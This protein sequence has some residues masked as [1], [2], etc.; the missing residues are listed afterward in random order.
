VGKLGKQVFKHYAETECPRQLFLDLAN[1]DP[2]WIAPFR[3]I[4]VD[5]QRP[6]GKSLADLG[7]TYEQTV[8]R[9]MRRNPGTRASEAPDSGDVAATVLDR[10]RWE[11]YADA[12]TT[13]TPTLFL[14]EHQCPTPEEFVRFVFDLPPDA[15][16]PTLEVTGTMR[17]DIL[18]LRHPSRIGTHAQEVM[19]DGA[20]RP[21]SPDE[22]A[23]R[24]AIELVDIK[25]THEQAVG[26]THLIEILYY[27]IALSTLLRTL[28]LEG[29]FFVSAHGHGILPRREPS[30]VSTLRTQEPAA[31]LVPLRWRDTL[32]LFAGARRALIAL[33]RATP[34]PIEAIPAH[35]QSACGRCGY[36][37]DCTKSLS[38]GTDPAAWDVSLLP[39]LKQGTAV[40]LRGLGIATVGD[41][42]HR[43]RA[44][45]QRGGTLPL[46][47]EVP[48]LELQARALLQGT[49]LPA[50]P[51]N[52][53]GEQMLSIALP[54]YADVS[55]L[56]DF[57][58]DPTNDVV[59]ALGL[60]FTVHASPGAGYAAIHDAWWAFWQAA[61]A[62]TAQPDW[63][64]LDALLDPTTR[65]QCAKDAAARHAQF[66]AFWRCL[67]QL[68]DAPRAVLEFSEWPDAPAAPD[69]GRQR[70]SYQYTYVNGGS[71]V[72]DTHLVGEH[73]LV[74]RA[75]TTLHAIF[76][77][78][79]V[80]ETYVAQSVHE[81]NDKGV[82]KVWFKR[83]NFAGFYWSREQLV[84]VQDL[85]ERHLTR[86]VTGPL[87]E[88]F[89]ALTRWVSPSE[90]GVTRATQHRKM[91]DLREFVE[92]SVGHP[93]ILN[94]T[95]HG[96][97]R[98]F[99]T[100]GKVGYARRYWA[101]YFNQMDFAAWH[102]CLEE[103]D[104]N[105]QRAH[106]ERLGLEVTRKL[107]ALQRILRRTRALVG[108]GIA[109]SRKSPVSTLKLAEPELPADVHPIAAMWV[110]Y[111]RINGAMQSLDAE[112]IRT[113]YPL[114]S[115][116]SLAA[117]EAT[118][119]CWDEPTLSARFT[120]EGLSR[121]V[122]LAEGDHVLLVPEALRGAAEW[123]LN[124]CIVRI[125]KMEWIA[126]ATRFDVEAAL[127]RQSEKTHPLRLGNHDA[128]SRWFVYPQ[129]SEPW[130]DPL[131]RLLQRQAMGTGWLGR[132]LSRLWGIGFEATGALLRPSPMTAPEVYL[133]APEQLPRVSPSLECSLRTT[134]HPPPDR[135][136][137]EAICMALGGA[138]SCIKGP[139]GTGKSQTIAALLD[140]FLL[141]RGTKPT[142]IL[143]TAFSYAAMRVVLDKV[144]SA[145]DAQGRPTA[146]AS[147]RLVWLR[148]NGREPIADAP[149]LA[150]VTD[151]T[152]QGKEGLTIDGKSLDR[153]ASGRL[154]AVLGSHFVLFANAFSLANLGKPSGSKSFLYEWIGNDFGFDLIVI[155]EASQVPTSQ[156][157]ASLALVRP[158]VFSLADTSP[159][160]AWPLDD[161]TRMQ[162]L[163]LKGPDA[164]DDLTRVV[165]VGDDNQ[166]PPV[167]PVEPPEKLRIALDSAFRYYVEGHKVP[168]R[169]LR[170]NYRSK[171]AIVDYTRSLGI[172]TEGLEAFRGDH[173]YPALP[174][175]P[176][177]LAD[178]VRR[179]LDDTVDVSTLIHDTQH[180]TATSALEAD[181]A[182]EL[183]VAFMDQMGVRD[184]EAERAF[185]D[186]QIGIVAPHNAQGRLVTRTL[187]DR[188]VRPDARRT[189][190]SD[191]ALMGC[192]RATI[193]SVE[194]FQGSDRTLILATLAVSSRDQ[195]AA[196]EAFLYDLNRFNVLTS[197]AR[198]KMVL[199]C[200][201]AFLDYVPDDR[202]VFDH[203]A[204][205]RAFAHDFCDRE[206]RLSIPGRSAPIAWRYHTR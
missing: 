27:G 13:T 80:Y 136:Q 159:P 76:V 68:R 35:I 154:D 140:E 180:E 73:A 131:S 37:A 117:A 153:R 125:T 103:P 148:S 115:I 50:T 56:F 65:D 201:R 147:T 89:L 85:L 130:L 188:L 139:P 41:V 198:Q 122:K 185:W 177:H 47:A 102:E 64:A 192:L 113:T 200:P 87:R 1:K 183:C 168:H 29:R 17:P 114:Q 67:Q 96:I 60:L 3:P 191:E 5:V 14:L 106:F 124:E 170:T 2:G 121:N 91:F 164:L 132:R 149:D 182:A 199:L 194:K 21:L 16:L 202:A 118:R 150:H 111:T 92:S 12:L 86:L 104:A 43:V 77:V 155:D 75:V 25:H 36:V 193:Y 142:R 206:E 144:R 72:G 196:E 62:S 184:P 204:R 19:P 8:Y 135:S 161:L 172:Y 82:A 34:C 88:P 105:Q 165:I 197:R 15:P 49:H 176:P 112:Y 123:A 90:S 7:H 157:M 151:L 120:V 24:I 48:A 31:L 169:Q 174:S 110:L 52:T 69:A 189:A 51:E 160:E 190:L 137:T 46:Y 40:Q 109:E 127:T 166:L 134:Q 186:D 181:L 133:F 84:H 42:A 20:L 70:V 93:Q 57:E 129:A 61:L 79:L 195:L 141:R 95:W 167:Q 116:A 108:E 98:A 11:A 156:L 59:F 78:S 44:L 54:R 83:P 63:S 97:D 38:P 203:A 178:W 30:E 26:K 187:Y 138:I 107:W 100:T 146:A 39:F 145:R 179:V 158:A 10:A 173:P 119:L 126:A 45:P 74:E 23:S 71:R 33:H 53:A 55:L 99:D 28:S 94:V 175:P 9:T 22:R 163:T 32:H 128:T 6:T 101:P 4:V 162:G 205:V 58:A 81:T 171:P 18:V 152:F 143:V 66:D